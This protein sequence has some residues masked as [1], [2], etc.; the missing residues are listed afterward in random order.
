MH[1]GDVGERGINR[2]HCGRLTYSVLDVSMGTSGARCVFIL[3]LLF[4][5][6]HFSFLSFLLI[7]VLY[8]AFPISPKPFSA[9]PFEHCSVNLAL[10]SPPP[11]L[12]CLFT[13]RSVFRFHR[14][15]QSK[16]NHRY[17][18]SPA[19]RGNKNGPLT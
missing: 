8:Q 17:S 4:P 10:I 14:Y 11:P 3:V 1:L 7:Y 15:M 18:S 6:R 5:L 12:P 13:C 9:S 16:L 19:S 2:T